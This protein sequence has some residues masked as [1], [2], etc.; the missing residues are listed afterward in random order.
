MVLTESF[1]LLLNFTIH[2][3]PIVWTFRSYKLLS[4]KIWKIIHSKYRVG[5]KL[6]LNILGIQIVI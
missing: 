4:L 5:L 3:R 1:K 2:G 6:L